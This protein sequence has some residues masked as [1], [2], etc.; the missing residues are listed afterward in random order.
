ML[1]KVNDIP[2]WLRDSAFF[3]QLP[4]KIDSEISIPDQFYRKNADID[5][6][7]DWADV[8][9]VTDYWNIT[10]YPE[11]IIK[12][13]IKNESII[14]TYLKNTD[15]VI[16]T[17]LLLKLKELKYTFIKQLK[18]DWSFHWIQYILEHPEKNWNYYILS[19][20]PNVTWKVIQKHP[21]LF[22]SW[23]FISQNPNITWDIILENP[24]KPWNYSA[25]SLN[26][27]ITIDI[28]K[29]N[30]LKS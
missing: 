21:E 22:T 7:E 5:C 30:P 17:V 24:E 11:S 10:E 23:F 1:L 9:S 16:S 2:N 15:E 28:V 8:I 6:I 19:F 25:L 14:E 26:P 13:F 12:Y 3:H 20:N 4:L 27:N 18:I 29:N